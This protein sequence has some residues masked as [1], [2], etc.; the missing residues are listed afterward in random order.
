MGLRDELQ[1]LQARRSQLE[2]RIEAIGRLTAEVTPDTTVQELAELVAE[3]E[4]S[5][6]LVESLARDI[7]D[8]S[9]A[10]AAERR[11]ANKAQIRGLEEEYGEQVKGV[12]ST[13]RR[14]RTQIAAAEETQQK[15]RR[16]GTE[17]RRQIPGWLAKGVDRALV[18]WSRHHVVASGASPRRSFEEQSAHD[19]LANAEDRLSTL[20]GLFRNAKSRGFTEAAMRFQAQVQHWRDEVERLGG[21][22][23]QVAPSEE[24]L[25]P[26]RRGVVE[27]VAAL[28]QEIGKRIRASEILLRQRS[29]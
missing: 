11:E 12:A 21:D 16:L 1:S 4:A 7:L 15:I 29:S 19:A 5:R 26:V 2:A 6:L 17:P 10:I 27:R 14:L 3:R 24:L 25:A 23:S 13:T 22:P 18:W 20:M 9:A 8:V 28:P